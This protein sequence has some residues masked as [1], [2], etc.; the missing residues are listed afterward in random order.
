MSGRRKKTGKLKA[1]ERVQPIW[2]EPTTISPILSSMRTFLGPFLIL[3]GIGLI[4]TY[5]LFGAAVSYVGFVFTIC[6][7]IWDPRLLQRNDWQLQVALFAIVVLF[8]LIFTFHYFSI[9]FPPQLTVM[10]Y[11]PG[12]LDESGKV[13]DVPWKNDYHE[14]KA[15]VIN[16]SDQDYTDVNVWV[17]TNLNIAHVVFFHAC[18][19]ASAEPAIKMTPV[20][21]IGPGGSDIQ[22]NSEGPVKIPFPGAPGVTAATF[23]SYAPVWIIHC[24]KIQKHN[25]IDFALAIVNLQ[26]ITLKVLPQQMPEWVQYNSQF[27]GMGL[28]FAGPPVKLGVIAITDTVPGAHRAVP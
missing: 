20:V 8:S 9:P 1:P 28:K 7:V 6:E 14:L 11:G 5:Y 17:S 12:V 23:G 10:D 16:P 3:S 25:G 2:P 24:D 27:E 19:N 22:K 13:G 18:P 26:R 4:S 21:V 15:T